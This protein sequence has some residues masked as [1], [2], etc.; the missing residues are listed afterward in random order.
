[1]EAQ[2]DCKPPLLCFEWSARVSKVTAMTKP[3]QNTFPSGYLAI[4]ATVVIWSTPSLFQFY[5]IRY[6]EPWSG[7]FYRYLVAFFF[8]LPFVFLRFDEKGGRLDGAAFVAGL[9][10]SLPNVL[11]HGRQTLALARMG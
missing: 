5:L 7:R 11:H 3:G 1:M 4:F 10:P 2:N 8:V 9:I 6:Y